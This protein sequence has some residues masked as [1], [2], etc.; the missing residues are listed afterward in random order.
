M[1][2]YLA[3]LVAVWAVIGLLG[4]GLT[5]TLGRL[6]LFNVG[7]LVAAG[8]G[9]Y[10]SA[11][12]T[13][14]AGWSPIVAL[15]AAGFAGSVVAS[16]FV[17]A[18][19]RCKPDAFALA[20]LC[21]AAAFVG[22][23]RNTEALT[24]G[25]RGLV[26]IPPLAAGDWIGSQPISVAPLL[27]LLLVV[28]HLFTTRLVRSRYGRVLVA[29]RDDRL[30]ASVRGVSTRA[31]QLSALGF[32][33]FLAGVAGAAFAH[34]LSVAQP[35]QFGVDAAF[36]LIAV[37]VLGGA[38]SPRGTLLAAALFVAIPEVLRLAP[39]AADEVAAFRQIAF[40]AILIVVLIVA[41]RGLIQ[42]RPEVECSG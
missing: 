34:Y 29:V 16:L 4:L 14:R 19:H 2:S 26:A 20:S 33:G 38:E 28:G 1:V 3:H 7:H 18:S 39:L 12:L 24:G 32:A 36:A 25:A 21:L 15:S 40:S 10:V 6:G 22:I 27:A 9:A 23:V 8:V 17:I 42:E 5:L 41:P 30:A 13:M 35:D 31:F 37:V 11:L